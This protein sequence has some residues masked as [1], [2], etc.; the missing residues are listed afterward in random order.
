MSQ[1]IVQ[2]Y[3]LSHTALTTTTRVVKV[4]HDL[5]HTALRVNQ[6]KLSHRNPREKGQRLDE[7]DILVFVAQCTLVK[8]PNPHHL[9]S[10]TNI[11]QDMATGARA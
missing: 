11:L 4:K 7:C 2:I 9:A 1:L 10:V 6:S 3:N 8:I 5:L